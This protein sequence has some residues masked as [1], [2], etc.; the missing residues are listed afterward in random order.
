MRVIFNTGDGGAPLDPAT[1][2][3]SDFRVDD[4]EPLDAKVNSS[5]SQGRH[6]NHCQG[7]GGIPAGGPNGH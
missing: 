3:A 2:S 5:E 4:A 7:N 6:S 1:V